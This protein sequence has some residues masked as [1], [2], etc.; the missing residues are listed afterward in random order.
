MNN[1]N[2]GQFLPSRINIIHNLFEPLKIGLQRMLTHCHSNGIERGVLRVAIKVS[3]NYGPDKTH[4]YTMKIDGT[5]PSK[6]NVDAIHCL[7]IMACKGELE[8]A[9]QD[10]DGFEQE[11]L[12]LKPSDV[13]FEVEV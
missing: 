6:Q 12:T 9:N 2:L 3:S 11:Y 13:T 4:D 8:M 10:D 5:N 1:V 7:I